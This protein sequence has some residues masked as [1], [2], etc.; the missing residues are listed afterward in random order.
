MTINNFAEYGQP[1]SPH[2]PGY[3]HDHDPDFGAI[4]I[5]M[6][7]TEVMTVGYGANIEADDFPLVQSF[8]SGRLKLRT[9]PS[10]LDDLVSHGLCK[11][12]DRWI[13]TNLYGLGR[14]GITAG[15]IDSTD[16]AYIHGS[17]SFA[18][19][20]ST[21]F[22]E[23]RESKLVIAEVGAGDDNWDFNSSTVPRV[24]NMAVATLLGP[25]H[26]NLTAPIQIRFVGRGKLSI[27]QR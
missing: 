11:K 22:Q 9:N 3:D 25:A 12:S 15:S 6:S 21:R 18:L 2:E 24:V 20:A 7:Q 1:S 19:M 27:A 26:Y 17:V 10:T 8:L 16:A 4:V 5:E 13:D 23:T 14:Y